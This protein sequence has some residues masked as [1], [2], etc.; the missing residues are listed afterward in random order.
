MDL[1][2]LFGIRADRP[3]VAGIERERQ[4]IAAAPPRVRVFMCSIL[5]AKA[6]GDEP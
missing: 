2:G 3:E 5:T 1:G 4:L 6:H